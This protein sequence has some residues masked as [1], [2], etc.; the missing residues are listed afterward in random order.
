M[1]TSRWSVWAAL[2][3][4]APLVG[5]LSMPVQ[6]GATTNALLRV[7]PPIGTSNGPVEAT[8]SGFTAG[9]SITVKNETTSTTV[10]STLAA[11]DGTFACSGLAGATAGTTSSIGIG[12]LTASYQSAGAAQIAT[13]AGGGAGDGGP[14]TE[15]AVGDLQ[16]VTSD[17]AG[18]VY[19]DTDG[20]QVVQRIDAATGTVTTVAGVSWAVPQ[21]NPPGF[22][23]DGGPATSAELDNP[24]GLAVDQQGDLFIADYASNLIREVNAATGVITTVAGD[25]TA[26]FSGDN[27]LAVN[28]ELNQPQGLALDQQGD[29]F[30]GDAGNCRVREVSATTHDISTVVGN[31]TCGSSG[32]GGPATSAELQGHLPGLVLDQNGNLYIADYYDNVVREV[33][34]TTGTITTITGTGAVGYTGDNGPATDAE[35]A[36]PSGLAIRN[37]N[38]LLI[39]DSNNYVIRQVDLST[40]TITTVAGEGTMGSPGD[41]GAATSVELSV[42]VG[43]A[44]DAS[45]DAFIADYDPDNSGIGTNNVERVDG[46]TADIST[47]ATDASP[48]CGGTGAAATMAHNSE[49][50]GTAVDSQGNLYF[51]EGFADVVCEVSATTGLVS[52]IAGTFGAQG[53]GGDGGAATAASLY[54]PFGLAVGGGKLYIADYLNNQVRRVNLSTGIITTVAGDGTQGDAGDN[55]P[56]TDAELSG[57]ESLALDQNGNLYISDSKAV[58]EV[59][60]TTGVITTV[61]VSGGNGIALDNAG[62]LFLANGGLQEYNLS[63]D[64]LTTI[65]GVGPNL[66]EVAADSQGN[67]Y[68]SGQTTYTVER[69]HLATG[70]VSLVAGTGAEGYS[71]DGGPASAAD[72]YQPM[73]ISVDESDDLYIGQFWDGRVREVVGGPSFAVTPAGLSGKVSPAASIGPFTVTESDALGN[74][75]DAPVGGT[76]V[77]LSSTS[78]TGLFAASSGGTPTSSVVI[79]SG[80]S[81]VNF[82]YGDSTTGSPSLTATGTAYGAAVQQVEIYGPPSAPPG[83]TAVAGPGPG[84]ITA[85]WAQA[86]SNGSAVT[87]TTAVASPGGQ[88][89]M[90]SG[91]SGGDCTISGLTGG[92]QYTVTFTATNAAGPGAASAAAPVKAVALPDA[93]TSLTAVGG[94]MAAEVSFHVPASDGG[95]SITSYTATAHDVTNSSR[96]GQTASLGNSP[97]LI[98]GLTNGDAYT[99]TVTAT[100]VVGTGPASSPSNQVTPAAPAPPPPPP[101]PPAPTPTPAPSH[102]YWLVGS[103]GGIFTFGSAQFYGSTG[104]LRLQRP[105][106]GIVPTKDRGGYW[107][108]ASDGGVF[109]FGDAGFYGSIPGLGLHPAGSGLPN[110][111]NAPIVGMVPSA[112][113]GGYFMVA[114]DGGVFA[115]GDATFAGSCPGIGGCGGA[116]VS[117]MPDSTGRGYWLVT[118]NGNVHAFGDAPNFG[119]PGPVGSP[120]TSAVRTPDGGGYWILLANGTVYGYGDA[121]NDGSPAGQFGG[122]DPATAIF[123]TSDGG[124]YWVAAADGAVDRYGDAPGDGSMLGTHLNGPVIAASG[125]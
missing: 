16:A 74:T 59:N 82:Y 9:Q 114:S 46:S 32:N 98:H 119:A 93:P 8:G 31:G 1:R 37:G 24:F 89:C 91:P 22:N 26:G 28:A 86:A 10:C 12:S 71:G 43:V 2:L 103:D 45:G 17:A 102:G 73:S 72:L 112:D 36:L 122:L 5:A 120:V 25:G 118:A 20:G 70:A 116:A 105:V 63:T 111:L 101:P 34:H 62:H 123:A 3:L 6:T 94:N 76:T 30:I 106:V 84:Q 65:P 4:M 77:S 79:P 54:Q 38:E 67:V 83:V 60:A 100:S 61:L 50:L 41:G 18:D 80:S 75:T 15:A 51:S 53:S 110:S 124:G 81:S 48:V 29:L 11:T 39:A 44:A 13:V 109:A 23:G 90:E 56:A 42:T 57:P 68:V 121:H 87:S 58:R 108:D 55:G 69:V 115:F 7:E 104:S 64:A 47:L 88:S 40:G 92:T 107:L 52:I 97:I 66:G 21:A 125:F 27:G 96:G 113:G 14:S 49:V 117:V 35:L 78:P 85:S 19:F 33:A 99:F 95:S